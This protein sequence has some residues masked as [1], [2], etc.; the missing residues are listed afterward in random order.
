[1]FLGISAGFYASLVYID[2]AIILGLLHES[3]HY[4]I[5]TYIPTYYI[6]NQNLFYF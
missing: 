3:P 2:I 6:H 1:M 4:N 5:P